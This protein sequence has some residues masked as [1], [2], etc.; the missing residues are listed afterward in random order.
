R[1]RSTS[2]RFS[3]STQRIGGLAALGHADDERAL[4]W[5][6]CSDV[7]A[8]QKRLCG[9]ARVLKQSGSIERRV[10]RGTTGDELHALWVEIGEFVDF[11]RP[12]EFVDPPPET[13]SERA[14]LFVDLLQ[15]EVVVAA[16]A[17]VLGVPVH[18]VDLFFD[19]LAGERRNR[20]AVGIDTGDLAVIEV[21]DA[22]GELTEGRYVACE[23]GRPVVDAENQWGVLS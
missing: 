9:N 11:D 18:R 6:G 8:R 4:R 10:I 20:P 7:L 13:L 15:H 23:V 22:V 17:R 16:F 2:S 1:A 5:R 12:A 3:E 21:D 19:R 14:R